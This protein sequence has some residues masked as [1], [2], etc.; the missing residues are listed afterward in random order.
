MQFM[1]VSIYDQLVDHGATLALSSGSLKEY[2]TVVKTITQHYTSRS[3][4]EKWEQW[5][6]SIVVCLG[7]TLADYLSHL[8]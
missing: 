7:P 1:L 3:F 5:N 4:D 6:T 8:Y 2:L